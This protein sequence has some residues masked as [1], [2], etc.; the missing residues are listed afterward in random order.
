MRKLPAVRRCLPVV[1]IVLWVA[2][3]CEAQVLDP[4]AA[5]PIDIP[6]PILAGRGDISA[7]RPDISRYVEHWTGVLSD[8]S[9][10]ASYIQARNALI[11]GY[12]KYDNSRYRRMYAESASASLGPL[13]VDGG[14]PGKAVNAAIALT[15]MAHYALL[16]TYAKMVASEDPGVRYLGWR[17]FDR[18][19]TAI[20]TRGTSSGKAMMTLL[21]KRCGI[22]TSPEILSA[23]LQTLTVR[24]GT[25]DT[26]VV[27]DETLAWARRN[28]FDVLA[29][30]WGKVVAQVRKGSLSMSSG[31]L[32]GLRAIDSHW[33]AIRDEAG[34]VT[35]SMQLVVDLANAASKAYLDA[36]GSGPVALA[37]TRVLGSAETLLQKFSGQSFDA[38]DAALKD[39]K[40]SSRPKERALLV[41]KAV[42]DW[43]T[44][45]ES[46]GVKRPE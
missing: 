26:G 44:R 43:I 10:E 37:N 2:S 29:S 24:Q 11:Q 15:R 21:A 31:S 5:P 25:L 46:R 20:L 41:R 33:P 23:Q 19:R 34:S 39:P 6:E 32:H 35:R 8:S 7:Y 1:G 17:G 28:A 3:A 27:D 36:N 40:L 14:D 9:D 42:L 12:L 30:C 38:I 16:D 18:I 4:N 13:A 22:E 45:L